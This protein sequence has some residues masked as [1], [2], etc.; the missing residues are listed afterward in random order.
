MPVGHAL[1]ERGSLAF[2]SQ[3]DGCGGSLVDDDDVVS[4]N[5]AAGNAEGLCPIRDGVAC[6]DGIGRGVLSVLI[7]FA[8]VD[9]GKVPDRRGVHHF[10]ENALVGRAIAEEAD[11]DLIGLA[12]LC[13]QSRAS[14]D[15]CK[16]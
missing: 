9:N 7:I 2:S 6:G 4:V 11:G 8:D 13:G 1:D 5:R 16:N 12:Q 10:E 3:G 15:A 14:R